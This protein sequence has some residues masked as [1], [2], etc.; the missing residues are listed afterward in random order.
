MTLRLVRAFSILVLM[1]AFGTPAFPQ[2]GRTASIFGVV[3]DSG[4]G[5]VPGAPVTV[6]KE[7]GAIFETVTNSEGVLSVPAVTAGT[8]TVT[9]CRAGS[10]TKR[11]DRCAR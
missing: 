3:V 1:A 9:R 8:Y 2:G 4:G 11:A 7:A 10:A 6:K 5:A